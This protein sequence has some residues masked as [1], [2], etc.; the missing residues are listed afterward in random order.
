MTS[1]VQDLAKTITLTAQS[2]EHGQVLTQVGQETIA[3]SVKAIHDL[4]LQLAEV[5]NIDH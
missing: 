5:D 1:T 2:A 4:S 3:A